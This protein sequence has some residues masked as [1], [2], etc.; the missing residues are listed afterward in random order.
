[1]NEHDN[2]SLIFRSFPF[3]HFP[4]KMS[5]KPKLSYSQSQKCL[6]NQVIYADLASLL[7]PSYSKDNLH[8]NFPKKAHMS[9]V[10]E[11]M[12]ELRLKPRGTKPTHFLLLFNINYYFI[13]S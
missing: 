10:V 1:M 3:I 8:Y 9:N 13:S 7:R 4:L 5:Y 6:R 12:D 11:K 2:I